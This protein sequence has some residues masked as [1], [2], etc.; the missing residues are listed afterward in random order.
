MD[1]KSHNYQGSKSFLI[2]FRNQDFVYDFFAIYMCVC[3]CDGNIHI[4][5]MKMR[6]LNIDLSS[7]CDLTRQR[8]LVAFI[9]SRYKT[10]IYAYTHTI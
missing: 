4:S 9:I 7:N 1:R 10:Y 2:F 5:A 3:V 6:E 8:T